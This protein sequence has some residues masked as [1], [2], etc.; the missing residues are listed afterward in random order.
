MKKL[1]TKYMDIYYPFTFDEIDYLS[2]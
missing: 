2:W 1:D